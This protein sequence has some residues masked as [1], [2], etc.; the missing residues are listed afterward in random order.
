MEPPESLSPSTFLKMDVKSRLSENFPS[1]A[2]SNFLDCL[3]KSGDVDFH[4]SQTSWLK[5]RPRGI[6]VPIIPIRSGEDVLT[7]PISLPIFPGVLPLTPVL[8]TRYGVL[9]VHTLPDAAPT[10]ISF[11]AGVRSIYGIIL[12]A[13]IHGLVG[14]GKTGMV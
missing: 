4:I 8:I 11:V 12:I 6:V 13:E 7:M 1:T 9:D 2:A 3:T 10:K 5:L 14:R